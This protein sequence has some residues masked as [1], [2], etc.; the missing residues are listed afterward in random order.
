MSPELMQ[1]LAEAVRSRSGLILEADKAYLAQT[2]LAPI[3]RQHGLAS[4]SALVEALRVRKDERI[5]WAVTD[6]LTTNET[7]FFRDGAP[8]TLLRDTVLPALA[9]T[10]ASLSVWSAACSTGQ[11]PYSIAM[12]V[13]EAR[14]GFPQ[15]KLNMLASDI[16]E[17]VLEK[18]RAG[19]YTSFEVQRGLPAGYLAK[20]FSRSGD[21]WQVNLGLR[22]LVRWR[23]F[24]LLE[25]MTALGRFDVVFCRNVL[26]YF[27]APT[28]R[29]VLDRIAAVMA[30]DG[31]L[32]LGGAETVMG[33]TD[34][35]EPV[36]GKPG[37]FARNAK[38][39]KAA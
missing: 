5:L 4:V 12:L 2:R 23:Q 39:I 28:K 37:L 27:D 34:A 8:F 24:N 35:F 19:V 17:R 32:F 20:Y 36:P 21:V 11:E 6:A 14:S 10:R 13:E 30:E 18:A 38:L 33:L 9:P 29:Q 26:I 15:M 25:Q 16:S 7:F 31:F 3:A 1:F 22:Q